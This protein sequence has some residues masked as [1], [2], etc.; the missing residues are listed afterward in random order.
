MRGGRDAAV[1][2]KKAAKKAAK[3]TP[4]TPADSA[5]PA[6]GEMAPDFTLP[7][8]RPEAVTDPKTVPETQPVTLSEYRGA[9]PVVL[10]FYPRD[11]TPGCT[12]EACDFRDRLDDLGGAAVL[13]VSTDDAKS[14]GRFI[15]KHGLTFPLLVDA[16]HAVCERYGVW[17]EK[18]MY[19][20]TSYGV[21]RATVLID[22]EGRVAAVWP[23]VR[24]PGHVEAVRDALAGLASDR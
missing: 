16:D 9:N 20:R 14:H 4:K 17:V 7:A 18:S 1:M 23:K 8:V 11:A 2:A 12:T 21:Q 3:N 13:G 19:G 22:T 24:V 10:Y 6:V 5:L 15:A